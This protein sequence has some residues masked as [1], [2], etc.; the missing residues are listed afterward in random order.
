VAGQ[1]AGVQWVGSYARVGF[2]RLFAE[3]GRAEEAR[4]SF[5]ALAAEGFATLPRRDDWLA[6][7]AELAVLCAD[8]GERAHAPALE[9]LLAPFLGWHAVYQGPL[10]YLGPVSRALAR[11]A[12]LQGRSAEARCLL[13]R[14]RAE[15]EVIESPPWIARIDSDLAR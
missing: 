9:T 5:R 13:L 2:A 15:A 11:L 6:S 12:E 14:A 10:F 4:T 8:L 3:L 1:L 7:V